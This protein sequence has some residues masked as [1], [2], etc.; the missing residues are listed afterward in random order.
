MD[1]ETAAIAR[2]FAARLRK[3]FSPEKIILFGSRARG[4]HFRTSDF[5]FIVVSKRFAG[6][7]FVLRPAA[8]YDLW[9]AKVDLEAICYTPDE[10]ARKAKQ[11]GTVRTALREGIAV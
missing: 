7:P 4:D 5:D 11:L 2:P 8:L 1:R 3:R 6:T 10:F 9:T